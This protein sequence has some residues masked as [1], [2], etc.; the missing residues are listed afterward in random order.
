MDLR[1]AVG[2]GLRSAHFREA[3]SRRADIDFVEVHA[4][5]YFAEG[6]ASIAV[7]QEAASLYPISL[8]G[9]GGGWLPRCRFHMRICAS[10]AT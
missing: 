4:E 3:L 9:T 1:H 7:L 8:H 2:V 10:C 6:G 5:N